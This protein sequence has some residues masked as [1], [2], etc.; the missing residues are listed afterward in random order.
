[1]IRAVIKHIVIFCLVIA[2]VQCAIAQ[3]SFKADE[4]TLLRLEKDLY[5][6]KNDK[7][8]MEANARL[9]AA[10]ELILKKENSFNYPFDSLKEIGRIYSP[11]KSFRIINWDVPKDDGT[12]DYF[13]FI[14]TYDTKR[15][16][17]HLYPLTD[18][19][20]DIKNPDNTVGDAAKWFGMLYYKIIPIKVK[21]KKYYTLLG[22]DGNDRL[23]RKKI[24]DVLYFI[25]DGSPR[26]GA[27]LFKLEKRSPKRVIFEFSA[28]ATMSLNYNEDTKQIV[29]DHL[30][31]SQSKFEG[32]FQYYGPDFSFDGLELIKGKWVYITDVDARNGKSNKDNKYNDPKDKSK[33]YDNKKFYA[34]KK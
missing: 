3:Q 1:M 23:T 24:V 13:G 34:P 14:Q 4:D 18:K 5:A 28:Q 20:A 29:F 25:P 21:R 8:K 31:P 27:D 2:S 9:K 7:V 11:D 22:A 30:A 33:N 26:F 16:A 10:F 19:S 32:Q 12:Y 17:N 15:K 6:S